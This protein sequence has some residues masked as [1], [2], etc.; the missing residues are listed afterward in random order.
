MRRTATLALTVA[1]LC[2]SLLPAAAMGAK[3]VVDPLSLTPPPN[4]D[5]DW[6][7]FETGRGVI[8][9]GT[10]EESYAEVDIGLE[11]DGQTVW[12]TGSGRAVATRWH[13]PEGSATRSRYA[14]NFLEY[15]SL[16]PSGDGPT[17][18]A[19]SSFARHFEY[20]EP[21]DLDTIVMT[22][23][24][25]VYKATAPGFGIIFHDSGL[26]RFV[27]GDPFGEIDVMRGPHDLYSSDFEALERICDVLT[28]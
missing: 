23:L 18:I 7:C 4:P 16:S 9:H 15:F 25:S 24:G 5:F 2:M 19:R 10:L 1:M 3:R 17:V 12:L 14:Y 13:T 27:A 26:I 22:E 6:S 28:Q 21:G 20:G 11:C 8:C